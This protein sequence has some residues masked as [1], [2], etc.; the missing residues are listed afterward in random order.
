ME[1]SLGTA[2]VPQDGEVFVATF[3]GSLGAAPISAGLGHP[4]VEGVTPKALLV[5]RVPVII[6]ANHCAS[7]RNS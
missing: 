3:G 1:P 6:V 7:T 4:E 5:L 2:A